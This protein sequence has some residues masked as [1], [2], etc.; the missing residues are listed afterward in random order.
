MGVRIV[1][2]DLGTTTSAVAFSEGGVARLLEDQAGRTL[3]PTVVHVPSKGAPIVGIAARNRLNMAPER[4]FAGIKR[5]LGV[6]IDSAEAKSLS[7]LYGW[8]LQRGSNNQATFVVDDHA[9]RAVDLAT[10]VFRELR[11]I[12]AS[13]QEENKVHAVVTVPAGFTHAQRRATLDAAERA[14]LEVE[15]LLNEPTAAAIAYGLESAVGQRI[16]VFDLGGGTFDITI[17]EVQT[18]GFE[19]LATS[20]DT[21]LGSAD[22]DGA[23]AQHICDALRSQHRTFVQPKFVP[24][25]LP[26]AERMKIEL[27]TSERASADV[28]S[29]WIGATGNEVFHIELDRAQVEA[30][31]K[32]FVQ[33][34]LACVRTCLQNAHLDI[35]SIDDVILVGGGSLMP[36]V[37]RA[38]EAFFGRAPRMSIDPEHVVALGAARWAEELTHGTPSHSVRTLIDRTA[39]GLGIGTVAGIVD[40]VIAPNSAVPARAT[41]LF[42]TSFDGQTRVKASVYQGIA[43][44]VEECQQI[45]E[46]V[47]EDLPAQRRGQTTVTVTFSLDAEGLITVSA[48]DTESGVSREVELHSALS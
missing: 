38:V 2:I 10:E 33:R 34:C 46:I 3:L 37:Q 22:I 12:A 47:L 43:R 15:R 6:H 40:Y 32:P 29:K 27:S 5:L 44:R 25:L 36:L 7:Q 39:N 31:A 8:T 28:T 13:H 18:T 21:M 42:T 9:W 45:G 11:S 30:L 41:R 26:A 16:A 35:A 17:L 14:G 24:R 1:G 19:V 48:V 23:I 20:G 4:T